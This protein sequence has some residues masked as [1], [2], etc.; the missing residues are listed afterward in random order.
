[1]AATKTGFLLHTLRGLRETFIATERH[2]TPT[3]SPECS[4]DTLSMPE[5]AA[6]AVFV[7]FARAGEQVLVG[8][9]NG[10]IAGWETDRVRAG[11]RV[12]RTQ[13]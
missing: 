10:V 11:E 9:S 12:S 5:I 7:G 8:F 1:M 2:K 13:S 4:V 6:G 3:L